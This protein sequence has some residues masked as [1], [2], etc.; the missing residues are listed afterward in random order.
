[1]EETLRT[2]KLVVDPKAKVQVAS[3]YYYDITKNVAHLMVKQM[4]L[5]IVATSEDEALDNFD[6]RS[7]GGSDNTGAH[8]A[9]KI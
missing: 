8:V 3:L 1:M 2:V 9:A 6:S 5:E 4:P 7:V